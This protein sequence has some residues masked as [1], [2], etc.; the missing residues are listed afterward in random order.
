MAALVTNTAVDTFID[1]TYRDQHA[2]IMK[3]SEWLARQLD[4]IRARMLESSR[5]LAEFQKSIGVADVD[6]NKST[7]TEQMAELNRQLILA[8]ADRIQLEALLKSVQAGSPDVLPEIRNNPVVQQLSTKLAE[9]RG[10][11]SQAKVIYGTNH[12]NVKKTSE[13]G[14]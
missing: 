11:L 14:G 3:S 1:D 2:A 4:D 9:L 7:F 8:Q 13:P 12:P 5:V 6:S 10:E